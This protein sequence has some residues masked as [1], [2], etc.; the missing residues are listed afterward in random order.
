MMEHKI[1]L[2]EDNRDDIELALYGLKKLMENCNIDVVMDGEQALE[3][4]NC[5]TDDQ[6]EKPD[7]ILLDIGLPGISGLEVLKR[8]RGSAS[9]RRIPIIILS[10]SDQDTDIEQSFNLGANSYLCKPLKYSAFA[11]VMEQLGIYWF[12]SGKSPLH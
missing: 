4:L 6:E 11:S 2:I 8:L 9:C 3:Y 5:D 7:L 1:L 10:A 12:S